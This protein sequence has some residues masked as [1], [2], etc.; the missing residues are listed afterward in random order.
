MLLPLQNILHRRNLSPGI[1]FLLAGTANSAVG[2][3]VI[4]AAKWLAHCGDVLAN[5]LGYGVGLLMSFLLNKNWTFGY[6]GPAGRAMSRFLLVF[7]LA[8]ALNLASVLLAIRYLGLGGYLAQ[9]LGIVPYTVFGF[10]ASRYYV[11]RESRT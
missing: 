5:A 2:L 4:Y 3:S 9:A 1:K 10:L 11:F 7:A 8:Y 6:N